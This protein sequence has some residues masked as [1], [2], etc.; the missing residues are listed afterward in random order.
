MSQLALSSDLRTQ[1]FCCT[2]DRILGTVYPKG[3]ARVMALERRVLAM[4]VQRLIYNCRYD[5]RMGFVDTT[6]GYTITGV[7]LAR[8]PNKYNRACARML[9]YENPLFTSYEAGSSC[10]PYAAFASCG[11]SVCV[12]ATWDYS[13]I[14]PSA[15][16]TF[17]F[18]DSAVMYQTD[19]TK[20]ANLLQSAAVA[21]IPDI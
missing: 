21:Y 16:L 4:S 10:D 6:D 7:R 13:C 8:A 5:I 20:P 15:T 12:V 11:E 17:L 1:T 3:S 18:N 2:A 19:N 14:R 9:M